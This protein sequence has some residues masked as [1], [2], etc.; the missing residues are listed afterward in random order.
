MLKT[1]NKGKKCLKHTESTGRSFPF[2]CTT[3]QHLHRWLI[4]TYS[5]DR[6]RGINL[7]ITLPSAVIDTVAELENQQYFNYGVGIVGTDNYGI[8]S[9][10][11]TLI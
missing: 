2:N 6:A 4:N 11:K 8:I 3:Y 9:D 5:S 1:N 7:N 10:S